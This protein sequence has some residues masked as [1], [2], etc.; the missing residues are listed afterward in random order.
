MISYKIIGL[1]VGTL[2]DAKGEEVWGEIILT[3]HAHNFRMGFFFNNTV[4][5]DT[6]CYTV[7]VAF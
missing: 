7:H 1:E 3:L 6:L 5:L 4:F 2:N